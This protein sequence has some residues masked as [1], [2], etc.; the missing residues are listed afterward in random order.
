MLA[1]AAVDISPQ[2][3]RPLGGAPGDPAAAAPAAGP[4]CA[5]AG[6]EPSAS[7]HTPPRYHQIGNLTESSPVTAVQGRDQGP[8]RYLSDH[9][10]LLRRRGTWAVLRIDCF[11]FT[12][13]QLH[14][15]RTRFL[16]HNTLTIA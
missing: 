6:G 14:Q 16:L 7:A 4:Y 3:R 5:A 12:L 2:I 9:F 15:P 1:S 8:Y 11:S 10:G 13:S